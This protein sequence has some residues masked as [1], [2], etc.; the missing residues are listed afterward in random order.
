VQS[1]PLHL[2]AR[3][4]LKRNREMV[5]VCGTF[6]AAM[7]LARWHAAE[8]PTMNTPTAVAATPAA[9]THPSH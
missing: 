1:Q 3:S 2:L 7:D 9:S 6:E 4:R 8:E 5:T